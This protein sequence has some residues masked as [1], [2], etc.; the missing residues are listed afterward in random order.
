MEEEKGR[1]EGLERGNNS[2]G[3]GGGGKEGRIME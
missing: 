3:E 2:K 1:K